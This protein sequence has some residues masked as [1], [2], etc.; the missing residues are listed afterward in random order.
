MPIDTY[1]FEDIS[2]E[3]VIINNMVFMVLSKFDVKKL[4]KAA[5]S[6]EGKRKNYIAVKIENLTA[7]EVSE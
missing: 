3:V 7:D 6:S 1:V 4:C 2:A 5:R